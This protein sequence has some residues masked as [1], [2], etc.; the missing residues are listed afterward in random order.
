MCWH[1][2][3]NTRELHG[4]EG[5]FPVHGRV[6]ERVC[7]SCNEHHHALGTLPK[8]RRQTDTGKGT[9]GFVESAS[10]ETATGI[11]NI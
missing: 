10:E 11:A 3:K 9:T 6:A 8:Q 2:P 7:K 4:D 5:T 1:L